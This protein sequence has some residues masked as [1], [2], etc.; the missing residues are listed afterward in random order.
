ML[1]SVKHLSHQNTRTTF[2]DWAPNI[3]GDDSVKSYRAEPKF[4]HCALSSEPSSHANY[5]LTTF[6]PLI[7][8]KRKL[9]PVA[10]KTIPDAKCDRIFFWHLLSTIYSKFHVSVIYLNIPLPN[11]FTLKGKTY[12]IKLDIKNT[13]P[14]LSDAKP[15]LNEGYSQAQTFSTNKPPYAQALFYT[16]NLP[17]PPEG[18]CTVTKLCL[19]KETFSIFIKSPNTVQCKEAVFYYY[20][21]II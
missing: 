13:R 8:N 4:W 18:T 6:L 7:P 11:F 21:T 3:Q 5:T 14:H 15:T 2:Q 16:F 1:S 17:S 10:I 12:A 19:L 9:L 20:E